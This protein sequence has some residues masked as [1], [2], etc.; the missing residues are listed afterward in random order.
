MIKRCRQIAVLSLYDSVIW[1]LSWFL[2]NG[3]SYNC[4]RKFYST[5]MDSREPISRTDLLLWYNQLRLLFDCF[6]VLKKRAQITQNAFH[7]R[8]TER[9]AMRCQF[10]STVERPSPPNLRPDGIRGRVSNLAFRYLR[11][12]SGRGLGVVFLEVFEAIFVLF[13]MKSIASRSMVYCTLLTLFVVTCGFCL[14]WKFC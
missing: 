13:G 1:S 6:S 14:L 10:F 7:P 8:R 12:W 3:E 9:C 4:K 5:C 11:H 2:V